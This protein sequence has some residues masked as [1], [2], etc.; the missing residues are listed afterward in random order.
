MY[1][2]CRDVGVTVSFEYARDPSGRVF[3]WVVRED[4]RVYG[5]GGDVTRESRVRWSGFDVVGL[6]KDMVEKGS[7]DQVRVC[8]PL[9]EK[10]G[11]ALL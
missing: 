5:V 9:L 11:I 10:G 6:V 2:G 4:S 1:D 8:L 7:P 3:G